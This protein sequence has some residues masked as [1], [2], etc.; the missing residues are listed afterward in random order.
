VRAP[1]PA[2]RACPFAPLTD[3]SCRAALR[4][5]SLPV[6]LTCAPV[7]VVY[8][9][10]TF[11]HPSYTHPPRAVALA[12][13]LAALAEHLTGEHAA[14]KVL[15]A[16]DTLGK[17]ELLE[18]CAAASGRLVYCDHKRLVQTR[19]LN[20]PT[21]HLTT[22]WHEA[23]VAAVPR[24]RVSHKALNERPV[25]PPAAADNAEDAQLPRERFHLALA[26]TGWPPQAGR[27]EEEAQG[28]AG[29]ATRIVAVPYSLH[30]SFGEL[31]ALVRALRPRRL[32]GLVASPR[33]AERPVD[34]NLHFQHL[35]SPSDGGAPA[36][37]AAPAA[38]PTAAPAK[39]A[40]PPAPAPRAPGQHPSLL[41]SADAML[42][43]MRLMASSLAFSAAAPAARRRGGGGVRMALSVAAPGPN[44]REDVREHAHPVKRAA[45]EPVVDTE[46]SRRAKR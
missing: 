1:F 44:V 27:P 37:A 5:S 34:P 18:A 41:L 23:A 43:R 3:A 45:E 24:W 7:D 12:L 21:Q 30:A 28:A 40:P 13:L 25:Q 19:A 32:V 35:L 38:A 8:L 16:V 14:S 39:Q 10:N 36:P 9:D 42:A 31:E 20:L 33:Y 17:E 46:E 26:P 11:C 2:P 6:A 22:C 15:L 4:S 29:H